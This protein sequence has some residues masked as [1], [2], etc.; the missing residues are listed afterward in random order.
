MKHP[1]VGIQHDLIRRNGEL[2]IITYKFG[3][4]QEKGDFTRFKHQKWDIVG[5][6][7]VRNGFWATDMEISPWANTH[8]KWQVI[9]LNGRRFMIGCTTSV[10][11][12]GVSYCLFYGVGAGQV[13]GVQYAALLTVT[14]RDVKRSTGWET[15]MSQV[16]LPV[17]L[18]MVCSCLFFLPKSTSGNQR[19]C[20]LE[21]MARV[22]RCSFSLLHPA[23]V[24][25]GPD[26]RSTH[27]P[28][29]SLATSMAWSMILYILILTIIFG[30]KVKYQTTSLLPDKS[31]FW[32]F[33]STQLAE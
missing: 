14:C 20:E 4:S 22:V 1:T 6:W 9:G 16:D 33:C 11:F 17:D 23:W 10:F 5:M 3:F 2:S 7:R 28:N 8:F 18:K 29:Q 25:I 31:T 15:E 24:H 13:H 26:R 27:E 12:S 32:V 19:F 30:C 21:A